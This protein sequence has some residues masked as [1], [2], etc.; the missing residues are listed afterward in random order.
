MT[1]TFEQLLAQD[2]RL[3]YKTKGTSME[4]MLRQNRDLVIIEVP[5]SRL[6]KYDVALYRRGE[7]Y[8]LHRVVDVK[9]DC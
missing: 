2:G 1:T 9:E 8:V 6:K 7:S 4:P 3:V 5:A